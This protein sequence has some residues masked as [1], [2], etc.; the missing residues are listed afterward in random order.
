[1]LAWGLLLLL[2]WLAILGGLWYLIRLFTSEAPAWRAGLTTYLLA[3]NVLWFWLLFE[4]ALP[5]WLKWLSYGREPSVMA[6]LAVP[7]GLLAAWLA[8][9]DSPYTD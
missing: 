4:P 1:M 9:G 2:I 8:R 6:V 7:V 3:G 5:S